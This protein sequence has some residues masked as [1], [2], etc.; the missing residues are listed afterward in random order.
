MLYKDRNNVQWDGLLET[1]L[2]D[3]DVDADVDANKLQS[4]RLVIAVKGNLLPAQAD[5]FNSNHSSS[6]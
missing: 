5:A 1:L 2:G 3:D 6:K 4:V